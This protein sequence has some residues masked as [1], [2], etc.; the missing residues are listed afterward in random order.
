MKSQRRSSTSFTRLS[1]N[2]GYALRSEP[3]LDKFEPTL[4]RLFPAL[5]VRTLGQNLSSDHTVKLLPIASAKPLQ[6]VPPVD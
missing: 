5:V 1:C 6:P 4:P 3:A 2:T